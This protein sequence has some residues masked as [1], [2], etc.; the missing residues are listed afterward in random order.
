MVNLRPPQALAP[1][2][3]YAFDVHPATPGTLSLDPFKGAVV[4]PRE[5][6]EILPAVSSE[7]IRCFPELERR[8]QEP[9]IRDLCL[10]GQTDFLAALAVETNRR[11]SGG[12]GFDVLGCVARLHDL[13]RHGLT[14]AHENNLERPRLHLQEDQ[15]RY[16]F[17]RRPVPPS[18]ASRVFRFASARKWMPW[19]V[20][21]A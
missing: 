13:V 7:E 2:G 8:A 17:G 21:S 3:G 11:I 20:A 9:R 5:D 19:E 18:L 16:P 15:M 14:R 6:L 10:D 4:D 12:G 1:R